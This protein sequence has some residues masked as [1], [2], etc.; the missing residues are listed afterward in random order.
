MR[1]QFEVRGPLTVLAISLAG[2]WSTTAAF[3]ACGMAA[4]S[5]GASG[6]PSISTTETSTTQ[7]LEQI[8]RRTQ[9]AQSP[10]PIPVSDTNAAPAVEADAASAAAEPDAASPPPAAQA[11]PVTAQSAGAAAKAV[12]DVPAVKAQVTAPAAKPKVKKQSVSVSQEAAAETYDKQPTPAQDYGVIEQS[13]IVGGISRTTAVWAQGFLGYDRHKN[14][15]PGNQENPTRKSVTGGG[16][17]GADWTHLNATNGV[18]AFQYGIFSGYSQTR[19]RISDTFFFTDEIGQDGVNDTNYFRSGNREEVDGPFIGTYLAYV[20]DSW[21]FDMAFKADF[22]DLTQS[23][24][25]TQR[26]GDDVGTQSGSASVNNY[27]IAANV[28]HR[29]DLDERKWWEPV[30]GVRYTYT[31][32]GNDPSNSVFVNGGVQPTGRLGLEDGSALRLQFGARL[33]DRIET[34]EGYIWT[35]TVGAFLYSDVLINGFE[36]VAGQTGEAVGPV[37][38]GK[39]RALGQLETRL[40]VGNGVTYLLQAE[41]RGG[42]DVFGAAG[43]IGM[44][45]EW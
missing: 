18:R 7:V 6:P 43:Q 8:R 19:T 15:A 14:V 38:E 33:G 30:F 24:T 13:S 36:S 26:C 25:L 21:T 3:A 17:I 20:Q 22:F 5:G 16:L 29:Y 32:F 11:K 2:S 10:Q 23:S 35:T 1:R 42:G 41:V 28:A 45:F 39:I 44:R 31:D 37:D 27:M 4:V 34:A 40:D 12:A 9:E